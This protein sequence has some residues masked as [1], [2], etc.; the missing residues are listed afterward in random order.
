MDPTT[1][2]TLFIPDMSGFSNFVTN[3]ETLHGQRITALLLEEIINSTPADFSVSEIEGD[4][5]FF[6]NE[7]SALEIKSFLELCSKIYKNF[8]IRKSQ[9]LDETV[10]QCGACKSIG[11]LT[12]KF[13][14]HYGEFAFINVRKFKKLFGRDVILIHR[15]LK[16]DIQSKEYVLFTKE[17]FDLDLPSESF[18]TDWQGPEIFSQNIEHFA[19][20]EGCY[21]TKAQ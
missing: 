16:N 8:H 6:F 14:V 5:I 7:G 11:K 4:A 20:V 9:M 1:K 18:G 2:A 19:N 17:Y 3:T 10:C 13:I 15:L 21:Y 12:L